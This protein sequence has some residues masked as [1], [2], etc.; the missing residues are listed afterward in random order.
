M[1]V[2]HHCPGLAIDSLVS[3]AN[4]QTQ[5]ERELSNGSKHKS[6]SHVYSQALIAVGQLLQSNYNV[7][8]GSCSDLY[9]LLHKLRVQQVPPSV[10]LYWWPKDH[11]TGQS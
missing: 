10:E 9:C 1:V 8:T 11:E 5:T 2:L 7:L 3:L 4:A 6:R